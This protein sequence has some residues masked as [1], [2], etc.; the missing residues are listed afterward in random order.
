MQIAAGRGLLRGLATAWARGFVVMKNGVFVGTS[1]ASV[2]YLAVHI[3]LSY[4]A[5]VSIHLAHIAAL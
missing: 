2:P 1:R 5:A 3:I 4:R